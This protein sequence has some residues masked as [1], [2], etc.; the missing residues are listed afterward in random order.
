MTTRFAPFVLVTA[1]AALLVGCSAESKKARMLERAADYYKKGEFEKA[2]IEYQNVLQTHPDDLTANE[3]LAMIWFDRGAT[4]RAMAYL[5]KMQTLAPGDLNL[6]LKRAQLI[7]AL[8][9]PAEA[10]REA[11]AILERSTAIAEALLLLTETVRDPE[12]FKVV[13]GI[14]QK[15]PERNTVPFHLAS[16]NLLMLRGD[17]EGAKAA[18]QRAVSVDTKSALA[19]TALASL[20]V[21][22]RN[23]ALAVAEF[24]KAAELAPPRSPERLK[25]PSYLAQSGSTAEAI[26][27][28][29]EI[30]KQT[31][32]YQPAW[33]LLAQIALKERRYDDALALVEN[34]FSR[35]PSDYEAQIL[36][37]QVAMARGDAKKAIED[38]KKIGEAFPNLGVEKQQLAMA[39]LQDND[40]P[41]AS[42]ALQHVLAI[43][44]GNVDATLLLTQL[45]LQAGKNEEAA[46][47]MAALIA[48]RPDLQQPY[49]L[50]VQAAK[51]LGKLDT[52]VKLIEENLTKSPKNIQLHY[53][54]GL[55]LAQ[56]DKSAEARKSF[57]RAVALAPASL[58]AVL[59]L[60]SL[61]VRERKFADAMKRADSVVSLQPSSPS[62]QLLKA[63]ISGAQGKW[64]DVETYSMKALEIDPNN[65]SAYSY[66]AE[67]FSAR[68]QE[69]GLAAKVEA[70][71]T[72]RVSEPLAVLMG[73]QV[74]LVMNQQ[75]KARDLYEKHLAA[76][77][78]STLILNNLANLYADRYKQ[79]DRAVELARKARAL[80]PSAPAVAD[81]LGWILYQ[82]KDYKE[83]LP[84]LEEAAKSMSGNAEVQYHFGMVNLRLGQAEPA[85]SALQRA[86]SSPVEFPGKDEAKSELAKLPPPAPAKS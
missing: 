5:S 72:P 86:V 34:V 41:H 21:A 43:N 76:K 51:G 75:D 33:R 78:G 84:L 16:A 65:S 55:I 29:T 10:R 38:L 40:R 3:R 45:N 68:K 83:A 14:V 74:F 28:L 79:L 11:Q 47:A 60:V 56:Q 82:K 77:P 46:N 39:Y 52:L 44:P 50:L 22:Q 23:P 17:Q 58:P 19:H 24:K 30:T 6:R 69:P 61:D 80:E 53:T 4:I 7:S 63:R 32:D 36:R 64:P 31:P 2:R 35:D 54:L 15:F 20:H 42:E 13:D 9:R 37:A 27:L 1:S 70:L 85:A 48:R 73:G 57:E 18:I 12:D 26:T 66:L 71:V 81:T 59:E 49:P 25:Y 62:G 67:S 8:G